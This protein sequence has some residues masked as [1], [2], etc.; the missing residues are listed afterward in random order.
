MFFL[1]TTLLLTAT[2]DAGTPSVD[3]WVQA[4][5]KYSVGQRV[6]AKVDD[7]PRSGFGVFFEL[8]PNVFM[9]VHKSDIRPGLAPTDFK[10]GQAVEV[11]VLKVDNE[12]HR[13]SGSVP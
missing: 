9:F 5:K 3:T 2:P 10:V 11:I 8:E 1:L 6:K 13:V 7:V 4:A 12:K